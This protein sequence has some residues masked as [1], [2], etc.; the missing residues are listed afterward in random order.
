MQLR[1][2]L[3]LLVPMLVVGLALFVGGSRDGERM[4][5]LAPTLGGT[6]LWND[7]I[8]QGGWRVQRLIAST[9][10]RLLDP[11]DVRHA[12]GEDDECAQALVRRRTQEE[13]PGNPTDMVILIHGLA[14]YSWTFREMKPALGRQGIAAEHWNYAS[15]RGSLAAHVD[16]FHH[17]MNRLQDV[18]RVTF[19]AHSLGGLLLRQ[20]L[21][22]DSQDWRQRIEVVGLVMIGTP[23]QGAAL[24][25]RFK[26]NSYFQMAFDQAGQD[27]APGYSGR[28]PVPQ[29]PYML[30][31]GQLAGEGNPLIPGA[32]DGVVGVAETVIQSEDALFLVPGSHA[33]ITADPAVIDQVIAYYHQLNRP[34][35]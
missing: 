8:L 29:V 24:A 30:I 32:D 17:M 18:E 15:T 19:V 10:C 11:F 34:L 4:N 23:N 35:P 6:Q 22:D 28:L 1:R 33:I 9:R 25:D 16:A 26:G 7:E 3:T 13:V 12:W 27:L 14:G 20:A 2:A 5:V 31:A 21:A